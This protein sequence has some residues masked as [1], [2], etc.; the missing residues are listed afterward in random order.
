MSPSTDIN[1]T[2]RTGSLF[3]FLVSF[4]VYGEKPSIPEH[5]YSYQVRL[6]GLPLGVKATVLRNERGNLVRI[7]SEVSHFLAINNHDS[8]FELDDCE[9]RFL[10]YWNAGKSLGYEFDDKIVIDHQ[11]SK[12]RYQGFTKRRGSRERVPV[13]K[14]YDLDGAIYVDKLSQFAAMGC[15]IKGGKSQF[16]LSYVDDSIGRYQFNVVENSRT[17]LGVNEYSIAHV[18]ATPYEFAEGSVHTPVNY[19]LIEELGFI[20]LKI[21]T[22]LKGLGLT[23]E[24]IDQAEND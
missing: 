21:Q 14:E 20:P 5:R 3:L 15:L 6:L 23:V 1:V 11:S 2:A 13:D 17:R 19:W 16:E 22:K 24:L 18:V 9:Y 7:K 12:I 8:Y 10:R 4:C